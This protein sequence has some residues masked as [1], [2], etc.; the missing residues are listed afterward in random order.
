MKPKLSSELANE[1]SCLSG[2]DSTRTMVFHGRE[3]KEL[4]NCQGRWYQDKQNGYLCLLGDRDNNR[5]KEVLRWIGVR[6]EVLKYLKHIQRVKMSSF[7]VQKS[8]FW[9]QAFL[10]CSMW[11]K[12]FW[13]IWWKEDHWLLKLNIQN[14]L[15]HWLTKLC[16]KSVN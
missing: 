13:N 6:L 14:I 7:L 2:Q 10:P 16:E 9:T 15:P 5:C 1:S 12:L 8:D 3:K 11:E 4:Q